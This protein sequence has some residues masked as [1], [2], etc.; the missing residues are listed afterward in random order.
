M[1]LS[2]GD[3]DWL[4][5]DETPADTPSVP[6]PIGLGASK[7]HEIDLTTNPAS[8][9]LHTLPEAPACKIRMLLFHIPHR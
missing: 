2:K 5:E 1:W 8:E 3:D 6:A 4:A 9:P 7:S